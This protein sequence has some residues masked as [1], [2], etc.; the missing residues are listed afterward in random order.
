MSRVVDPDGSERQAAA[1]AL[2][3]LTALEAQWQREQAP[4]RAGDRVLWIGMSPCPQSPPPGV[5][6]ASFMVA[7]SHGFDGDA[8]GALDSL[9]ITDASASHVV[10]QHALESMDDASS[11]ALIQECARVLKPSGI[12]MLYGFHPHSLWRRQFG[13]AD[14]LAARGPMHWRRSLHALGFEVQR[15]QRIGSAFTGAPSLLDRF[16]VAFGLRAWR[17]GAAIIP[18]RGTVRAAS[19]PELAMATRTASAARR[20]ARVR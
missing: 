7:G 9:P 15:A 6:Q 12:L 14:A 13:G 19:R 18:L 17:A 1:L 11:D 3:Q 5:L 4:L 2:A 8:M 16:G 10:L 20:M